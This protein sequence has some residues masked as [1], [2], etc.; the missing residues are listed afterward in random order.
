MATKLVAAEFWI[1]V[2]LPSRAYGQR[3]KL[4]MHLRDFSP[5]VF[6]SCVSLGLRDFATAIFLTA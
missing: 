3:D 6:V 1:C 4:I 5:R 2:I